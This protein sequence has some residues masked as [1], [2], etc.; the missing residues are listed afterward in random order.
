VVQVGP[1]IDDPICNP[2]AVVVESAEVLR[3][4][5]R[6]RGLSQAELARRAGTSQPVISAYERGRRDPSTETL[7]R[8]LAAAGERLQ[9]TLAPVPPDLPPPGDAA[10]HGRRLVDVLLLAD[11][12]PHRARGGLAMPRMRSTR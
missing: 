7:R 5:R 2:Y 4:A 6:R 8:L 9:L 1:G 10:E 11:A 12:V 3:T